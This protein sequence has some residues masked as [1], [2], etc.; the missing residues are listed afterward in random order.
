M[1]KVDRIII[2]TP[3]RKNNSW[4]TTT[5]Y[6]RKNLDVFFPLPL[7]SP[8]QIKRRS[9]CWLG[10]LRWLGQ[11]LPFRLRAR[12]IHN[13]YKVQV[14]HLVSYTCQMLMFL[15][16]NLPPSWS[17][18]DFSGA[19][20]CVRFYS[21][22]LSVLPPR[23]FIPSTP[24][25]ISFLFSSQRLNPRLLRD[26]LGR[27]LELAGSWTTRLTRSTT[28][29]VPPPSRWIWSYLPPSTSPTR[30]HFHSLYLHEPT[31]SAHK[32]FEKHVVCFLITFI[33]RSQRAPGRKKDMLAPFDQTVYIYAGQSY[34]IRARSYSSY[35]KNH[36]HCIAVSEDKLQHLPNRHLSMLLVSCH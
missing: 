15:D 12:G 35:P 36:T 25:T 3:S 22:W 13:R 7:A 9:Q 6:H 19:K 10:A 21:P 26:S 1:L 29:G 24:S 18:W 14:E 30:S 32:V 16:L 2:N 11:R 4:N 28:H 27:W 17:E 23:V 34:N 20:S 33:P 5:H 31:I 8:L